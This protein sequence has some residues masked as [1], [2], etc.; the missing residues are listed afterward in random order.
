[1]CPPRHRKSRGDNEVDL[2]FRKNQ[3]EM[4]GAFLVC[5]A[6][7]NAFVCQPRRE[8]RKVLRILDECID[9]L[10]DPVSCVDHECRTATQHPVGRELSGGAKA[11]EPVH[12]PMKQQSPGRQARP[13][14][15]GLLV[16]P[17]LGCEI[18]S[19]KLGFGKAVRGGKRQ[20][21]IGADIRK[22]RRES[23]I[24]ARQY[25]DKSGITLLARPAGLEP[26]QLLEES[27]K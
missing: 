14:N 11:G 3:L 20:Y 6:R 22:E 18:G 21:Q 9:F 4:I 10:A 27:E 13:P 2:A 16:G 1:M 17:S 26:A 19:G 15:P 25:L 24:S 5:L 8:E 12:R 23:I 7:P